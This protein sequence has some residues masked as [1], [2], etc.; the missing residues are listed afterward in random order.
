MGWPVAEA[1][2]IHAWSRC[3]HS[4]RGDRHECHYGGHLTRV[5]RAHELH[6]HH[7][8]H[9]VQHVIFGS[10]LCADDRSQQREVRGGYQP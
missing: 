5:Q 2:K 10:R 1:D 8:F 9:L 6:Q 7:E 3:A 4:R